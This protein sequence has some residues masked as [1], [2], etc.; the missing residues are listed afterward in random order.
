M[1]ERHYRMES[2]SHGY[3]LPSPDEIETFFFGDPLGADKIENERM[4]DFLCFASDSDI[5][6][7]LRFAL[8]DA[9]EN[10]ADI[11]FDIGAGNERRY[12]CILCCSGWDRN[13]TI[14]HLID[15]Y[16]SFYGRSNG[17]YYME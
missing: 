15:V 7:L 8:H 9:D 4:F 1:E 14:L 11:S 3:V 16:K 10:R 6:R 5:P 13:Q 12:V 17:V 2:Y